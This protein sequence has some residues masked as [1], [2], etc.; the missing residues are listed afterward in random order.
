[1]ASRALKARAKA[2]LDK[3]TVDRAM[4]EAAPYILW[5]TE[6]TNFGLKVLPTGVKSYVVKYRLG[7]G[8]AAAQKEYTIGRHGTVTPKQ[9]RDQAKLKLAEAQLGGNPQDDRARERADINMAKLCELYL[10][11]GV[12]TKKPSTLIADRSRIKSHIIPLLGRKQISKITSSDIERFM[13]DIASGKTAVELKPSIKALRASGVQ[14]AALKSAASRKRTD[15]LARGGKGTAARTVGLLGGIFQFAMRE[16]LITAN[17]VRGVERFRDKKSQ[18]FLNADEIARLT[19]ALKNARDAGASEH[20][21]NII[22]LLMVTGARRNEIEGLRWSEV[23]VQ[24]GVI[25]LEDAKTGARTIPLGD[26]AVAFLK[27]LHA[28]GASKYVFPSERTPE[29]HYTGAP[30]V[31]ERVRVAAGLADVRLH[32]LRHTFA[33]FAVGSGL[34][35]PF[36]GALLGHR[37]LKTTQQY[38]HLSDQPIKAAATQTARAIQQAMGGP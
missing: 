15:P 11:E 35:L 9:A 18:R 14:G 26:G 17:P 1:M 24:H 6:L 23:D 8:R 36:V 33:S 28:R 30:K 21:F 32:D 16:R 5:D 19:S 13:R 29:Q 34:S 25:R 27:S 10:A 22:Y 37:D 7:R 38:A 3:S 4:A 2:R 31:W 12:A 20:A